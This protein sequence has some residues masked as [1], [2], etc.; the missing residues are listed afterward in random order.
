MQEDYITVSAAPLTP[1][2]AD[3]SGNPTSGIAP[4]TVIFTDSS[5]NTPT[6]WNWSFGDDSSE[7]ATV[8]NPV[9][10]YTSAAN[11]TVS[12]NA[13]NT[14]GS[15]TQTRT[16]YI[17]VTSAPAPLTPPVADFSGNPTSGIAPLTVTFTDSSTNTPTS[18]YWSFGDDSSNNVTV[19]NPVHTYTSAGNYTVSLN[20]TNTAGLNIT[21]KTSYINVTEAPLGPVADFS[22]TPTSGFAPLTVQFNDTSTGFVS[23]ITYHWDFG[24]GSNSTERDPSHTYATNAQ[25]NYTVTLN[26]TGN[27]GKTGSMIKSEYI[28]IEIPTIEL[29]ISS[30]QSSL[31]NEPLPPSQSLSQA[32]TLPQSKSALGVQ[33]L[34]QSKSGFQDQLL[35]QDIST[36]NKLSADNVVTHPP[37]VNWSL[38]YGENIYNSDNFWFKVITQRNWVVDVYDDKPVNPGKMVEYDL[39]THMYGSRFLQNALNVSSESGS[40]VELSDVPEP[41][42]FGEGLPQPLKYHINL[43]QGVRPDDARLSSGKVYRIVITLEASN[44][45]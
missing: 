25:E 18:W 28:T 24:D 20:A 16:E 14:N 31:S 40:Y 41:I 13:S 23:P 4:L 7:N 36:Q 39:N 37:L 22:G 11:Y 29:I 38:N 10:T 45:P 21:T 35:P 42:Q 27:Y 3:F 33:S 30:D 12:L 17:N 8:Q 2:V 9:H 44:I 1:P 32:Q 43:K 5:T 34:P 26:V 6:N 15:D 19:Q